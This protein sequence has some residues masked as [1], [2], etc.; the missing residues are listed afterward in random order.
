MPH[1]PPAWQAY[2]PQNVTPLP[3]PVPLQQA[4]ERHATQH[5]RPFLRDG[6]PALPLSSHQLVPCPLLDAGL[7]EPLNLCHQLPNGCLPCR[8]HSLQALL[9]RCVQECPPSLPLRLRGLP[10]S[11]GQ[12]SIP[13]ASEER[14][15]GSPL[16]LPLPPLPPR[17]PLGPGQGEGPQKSPHLRLCLEWETS[18]M[19]E[20]EGA[21][22][23]ARPQISP[24]TS[25]HHATG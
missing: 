13:S 12:P 9:G 2:P 14:G 20:R 16:C 4:P 3:L 24:E 22:D 7:C 8:L 6:R 18:D 25:G 11:R 1:N 23:G 17:L 5:C 10:G 15:D 19:G 21:G